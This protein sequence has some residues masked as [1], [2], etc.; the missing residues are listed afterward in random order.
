MP[1]SSATLLAAHT[2]ALL[3]SKAPTDIYIG[4]L[5]KKCSEDGHIREEDALPLRAALEKHIVLWSNSMIVSSLLVGVNVSFIFSVEANSE[6]LDDAVAASLQAAFAILGAV[7]TGLMTTS[8]GFAYALSS[9]ASI[10]T[11]ADDIA[12]FFANARFT[13][14]SLLNAAGLMLFNCLVAVGSLLHYGTTWYAFVCVAVWVGF[15]LFSL[16]SWLCWRGDLRN[17]WR[18]AAPELSAESK[19]LSS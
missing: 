16:L 6:S 2:E 12:W 10:L 4:Q 17:L 15:G 3:H 13:L 18:S 5:L 14:P 11:H 7:S 9:Y 19:L 1:S 8:L